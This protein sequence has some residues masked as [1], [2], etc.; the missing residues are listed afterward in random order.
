[1]SSVGAQGLTE[2]NGPS[3]SELS[4]PMAKLM[5][6]VTRRRG[7]HPIKKLVAG[8]YLSEALRATICFIESKELSDF[9]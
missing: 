6:A 5:A 3:I 9:F 7:V 2:R 4:R 1:M 8:E